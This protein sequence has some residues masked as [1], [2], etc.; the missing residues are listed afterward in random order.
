MIKQTNI[1]IIKYTR[2]TGERQL[3]N[4]TRLHS[5]DTRKSEKKCLQTKT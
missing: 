1:Y 2:G 4:W 5:P 3:G